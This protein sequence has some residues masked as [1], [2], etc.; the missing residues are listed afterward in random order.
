MIVS[1]GKRP[2]EK[3]LVKHVQFQIILWSVNLY[4]QSQRQI[5]KSS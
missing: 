5:L 4:Y 3:R 2:R 1:G